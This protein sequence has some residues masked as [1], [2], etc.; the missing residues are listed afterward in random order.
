MAKEDGLTAD[1]EVELA[2]LKFFY[3]WDRNMF[4][5]AKPHV[6]NPKILEVFKRKYT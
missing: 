3:E 6:T 4:E 1:Q 2:C 5:E